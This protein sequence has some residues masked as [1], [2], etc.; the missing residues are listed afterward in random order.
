MRF[1]FFG[2]IGSGVAQTGYFSFFFGVLCV[3]GDGSV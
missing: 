1:L 2:V 3:F